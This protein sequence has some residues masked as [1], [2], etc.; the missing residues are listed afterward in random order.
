MAK[1][2]ETVKHLIIINVLFFIA[3]YVLKTRGINLE[4]YLALF[5]I[6]NPMFQPWQFVTTM[7]MHA[8][9]NH[10]LF[11]MLAL[12]MFGS[13]LEEMWGKNKFLFYYFSTGI[14][15]SLIYTL[16]NY[17]QFQPVFDALLSSGLQES[18]ILN[19]LKTGQYNTSILERVSAESLSSLY[20]IFNTPAV[21]ASGAIMGLLVGFGMLFPNAE[22]MLLFFPVPVK[23]K[24]FIPVLIGLDVFSG[25]TGVSVFSPNNTAYWAH[26]G[27]ALIGLLMMLYWKRIQFDKNRWN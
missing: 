21:G 14:G 23:A 12:W 5:F 10:I 8:S 2:T 13:P 3:T 11:N 27:G 15:A 4:D 19:I 24:Y 22:L 26:I 7:F 9:V 20:Q 6:K 25:L 16:A 1:L 18:E 17:L